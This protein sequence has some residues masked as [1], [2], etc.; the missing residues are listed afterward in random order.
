MLGASKTL[1]TL[2][3][4]MEKGDI[5]MFTD[6]GTYSKWF[7]GKMAEVCKVSDNGYVRV[8]WLEPVKYHDGYTSFS[9]FRASCFSVS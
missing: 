1:K 4:N 9:H 2:E 6:N 5:V 3:G 7:Y 8:R